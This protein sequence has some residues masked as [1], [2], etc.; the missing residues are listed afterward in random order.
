MPNTQKAIDDA[1]TAINAYVATILKYLDGEADKI[2]CADFTAATTA[3]RRVCDEHDKSDI[4]YN[5]F[6]EVLQT[7][8]DERVLAE[9]RQSYNNSTDYIVIYDR[10]WNNF[11][12]FVFVTKALF[13]YI[14]QYFLSQ[15]R[16][17][18]VKTLVNVALQEFKTYVFEK[19]ISHLQSAINSEIKKDRK[20]EVVN[21]PAIKTVIQQFIY[22]GFKT[23]AKVFIIKA[24]GEFS[25]K[26]EKDMSVYE[27]LLEKYLFAETRNYFQQYA[28]DSF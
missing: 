9:M 27:D 19:E 11:T 22:M 18:Q 4:M 5:F 23:S 2:S 26:G 17:A 3:I 28:N 8:M 15:A 14:D 10:C 1:K 25:W 24:N 21:M 7:Y 20:D 6:K 16:D 12:K 13:G